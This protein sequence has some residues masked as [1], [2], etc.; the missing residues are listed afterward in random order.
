MQGAEF[1][2]EK[3]MVEPK[4]KGKENGLGRLGEDVHPKGGRGDGL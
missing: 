4:R 3:F 1:P 2:H